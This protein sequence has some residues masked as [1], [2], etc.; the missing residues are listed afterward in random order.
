M[1]QYNTEVYCKIFYPGVQ[2]KILLRIN[3]RTCRPVYYDAF[4]NL[5]AVSA[6]HY[7]F[8]DHQL[9]MQTPCAPLQ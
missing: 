3:I 8:F 2:D 5:Q 7:D 6:A 9:L 1:V 4:Q